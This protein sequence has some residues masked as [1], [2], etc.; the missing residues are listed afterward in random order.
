MFFSPT[1]AIFLKAT[2][3]N[4]LLGV[5]GLTKESVTKNL[6]PS[7]ATI[8]GHMHR[9]PK[10]VQSTRK[11]KN[12]IQNDTETDIAPSQDT[13]AKC[14]VFCFSA[15]ADANEP[16]LYIDLMGKFPI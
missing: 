5:P 9:V 13:A 1:T 15:L 3:N 4:K 8:K 7:L 12:I 11:N 16:T 10:N 6:P 14:E 2:V